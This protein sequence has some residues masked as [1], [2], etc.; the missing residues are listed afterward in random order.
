M[1][2]NIKSVS[3]LAMLK[4]DSENAEKEFTEI[5]RFLTPPIVAVKEERPRRDE[6]A[7]LRADIPKEGLKKEDLLAVAPKVVNGHIAVPKALEEK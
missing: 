5:L 1:N 2:E 4:E 7:S 6:R 3:R